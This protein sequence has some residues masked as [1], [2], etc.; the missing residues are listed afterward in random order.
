MAPHKMWFDRQYGVKA[1]AAMGRKARERAFHAFRIEQMVGRYEELY[2]KLL[3]RAAAH[4][5]AKA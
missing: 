4:R 3:G 1:L 2:W 5:R